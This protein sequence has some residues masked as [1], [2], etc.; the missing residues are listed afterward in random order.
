LT[1]CRPS[2]DTA[3][4]FEWVDTKE[5]LRRTVSVLAREPVIGFDLEADS[6]FHFREKVC[7]L[8]FSTPDRVFLADPLALDD[9]ASV[10]A[11]LFEA[12]G[13]VKVLH[14]ADYDIRSLDRD[15]GIHLRG[16]F[17]TQIA[18]RFLGLEET[19]LAGLLSA[20]FGIKA[21]KKFQ[22]K[23]WS[24][25]PLPDEMLR[26]GAVDTAYLL[27]LYDMLKE[28]L[29]RVGRLSW[30]EEECLILSGVRYAP[31]EN[32]FL[33]QRL[34]GAGRLDPRGLAVAEELLRFRM[35]V[36]R[37]K[38]RPPF[39]VL[40][41]QP[42]LEM[43]RRRPVTLRELSSVPGI[44]KGLIKSVG[45][46]LIRLIEKALQL[47]ESELP[48]YPARRSGRPGP[49]AVK[50]LDALKAWRDKRA[51][52]LKL[53]PSVLFTNAQ[54]SAI[55]AARPSNPEELGAMPGIRRWQREVFGEE[56]LSV[57]AQEG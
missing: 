6:L 22:K 49:D 34:R 20:R 28:E 35:D 50:R 17:D 43:S 8:Q 24:I 30:V 45:V 53:D 21:E 57:T 52:G 11:P 25:R 33:F 47:P 1:I 37:R 42:I 9:L 12:G 54:L 51:A 55:S 41:N 31:P 10:A 4:S 18:A 5:G 36:A 39:K 7:L 3:P 15:F 26:Y 29:S 23:N 14:G 32:E 27:L 16:L 56:V 40:G 48:R 46:D 2:S 13:I 44:G 38:D 19:G